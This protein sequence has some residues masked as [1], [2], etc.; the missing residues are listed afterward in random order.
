MATLEP[1]EFTKKCVAIVKFGPA[2]FDTDGLRPAEYFQVTIDPAFV[3]GSGD[4]IRFGQN[5]GDEIQG[6]QRVEAMTVIEVLAEWDGVEPP[7]IT[8]GHDAVTMR[9]LKD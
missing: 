4:Y 8:T 7:L 9:V 5:P 3:S 1:Q 2:G 6:W